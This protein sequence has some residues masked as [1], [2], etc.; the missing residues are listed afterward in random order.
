LP[1]LAVLLLS[2]LVPAAASER[3]EPA[4]PS[5]SA[6]LPVEAPAS[7]L[8]EAPASLLVEAPA[9]LLVV[10]REQADLSGA[11]RI[12]DR[13]ERRRF[14]Y[15][16][17]RAQAEAT[18]APLRRELERRG[19]R[20]RPHFLVNLLEVE[21]EAGGDEA[22]WLAR[23]GDV[24][25]LSPNR[26]SALRRVP[27]D[28]ADDEPLAALRDA[29]IEPNLALI[30]ASALWDRGIT[31]QGI[32]I[33]VADT[34]FEWD[35]PALKERYRGWDE[36]TS[37]VTHDYNWHDA[38]HENKSLNACGKD[39]PVPC[40]D[41]GHGT[42]T[43][44][45]AVGQD[46]T[47]TIGAAP[48]ARLIGCRNMDIGIGTPARYIECFEWFLAPT[49]SQNQNP[50][51]ELGP[52]VVNNSWGCPPEEGCTDP[53][54][55]DATVN[56]MRAAGIA[57]AFA[58]G[59]TFNHCYSISRAPSVGPGAFAIG[60]TNL[61]DTIAV[62]SG[63]G[64]VASDGS[65]RMKPDLTA[66][67]VDLRTAAL[68]GRYIARFSGTSGSAP[69]VA[70]A[71]ALLWSAVPGLRG[72]V[73]ATEQILEQSAVPLRSDLDCFPYLGSLVPNPV[74][75]WGRLDVA[76]AYAA[77]TAREAPELVPEGGRGTRELARAGSP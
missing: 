7:L 70:G 41:Q 28:P 22:A 15:E 75:G 66:P 2:A 5:P 52:D 25:R 11:A 18:Q 71:I 21:V 76:N 16:A 74:F 45:L 50:R 17:L 26:P 34:G 43:S 32:V 56:S 1:V 61:D 37:T 19:I 36:S 23:R 4:R 29:A 20:Y 57:M 53:D 6:S 46:A 30:G 13:L 77:A 48:G 31:G 47:G 62:F 67:G 39:S 64:P 8:V 49:D 69:E 42:G 24:L 63:V 10:M 59:N 44:G 3:A 33:G 60:A 51:P 9:S 40:D 73:D 38:V 35:H 65:Y 55:L 14:V 58:A 54:M 68:Q 12:A 27:A 72:N